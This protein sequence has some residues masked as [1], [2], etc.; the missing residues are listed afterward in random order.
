MA[1]LFRKG[2]FQFFA[3]KGLGQYLLYILLE[4]ALVVAGILI[5]LGIN[6]RNER[7]KNEIKAKAILEEV[8][9]DLKNNLSEMESFKFTLEQKD[10]LIRRVMLDSVDRE[11]YRTDFNYAGLTMTYASI[12]FQKNGFSNMTRQS[13]LFNRSYDEVFTQLETI[14]EE[15][16]KM[17][18]SMQERWS[19]LVISTIEGWAKDFPWMYR[20]SRGEMT[21]EALDYFTESPFY[22]NSVDIYRTYAI[23]NILPATMESEIQTALC[24]VEINKILEPESDPYQ[25]LEKYFIPLD[26]ALWTKDTG[27]YSLQGMVTFK[28]QL[29]DEELSFGRLGSDFYR[30]YPKN[31]S[32]LSLPSAKMRLRINRAKQQLSI[33]SQG[34]RQVLDKLLP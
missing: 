4:M 28:L 15:D 34:E 21:D 1:K 8:R 2:R 33:L 9:R 14:Y 18:E 11:D 23:V 24:L 26:E 30:V 22:L 27:A 6:N 25:G 17:I 16:Y 31:D 12:G 13:N 32:T 3:G 7:A 10:S 29:E 20:L 19:D 5:A